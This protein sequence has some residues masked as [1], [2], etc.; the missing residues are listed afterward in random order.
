MTSLEADKDMSCQNIAQLVD[1]SRQHDLLTQTIGWAIIEFPH[2]EMQRNAP[3]H[4]CGKTKSCQFGEVNIHGSVGI[5]KLTTHPPE[6]VIFSKM[7]TKVSP[8]PLHFFTTAHL[9]MHRKLTTLNPKPRLHNRQEERRQP[10]FG[11]ILD[12]LL[13]IHRLWGLLWPSA[14]EI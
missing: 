5:D 11:R 4:E 10:L 1:D 7:S 8:W 2:G 12:T 6:N 14:F 9:V 3:S 13:E